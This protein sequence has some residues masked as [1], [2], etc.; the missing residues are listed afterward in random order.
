MNGG[1][2]VQGAEGGKGFEEVLLML[3]GVG[4]EAPK[5]RGGSLYQ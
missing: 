3:D 2:E 4:K 1:D 5:R